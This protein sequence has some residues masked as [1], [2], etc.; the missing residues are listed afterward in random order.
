MTT[1]GFW[2]H[3]GTRFGKPMLFRVGPKSCRIQECQDIGQLGV[4]SRHCTRLLQ[5][6]VRTSQSLPSDCR[7]WSGTKDFLDR[8]VAA[9][10]ALY[11]FDEVQKIL[12]PPFSDQD[13]AFVSLCRG[14]HG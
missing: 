6:G 4:G 7:R 10:F 11:S 13:W 14:N 12:A 1:D 2:C 5:D 9:H 3:I 8:G